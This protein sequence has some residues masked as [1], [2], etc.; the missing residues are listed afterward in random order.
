MIISQQTKEKMPRIPH[1]IKGPNEI[2]ELKNPNKVAE[3]TRGKVSVNEQIA[4]L[5]RRDALISR[6]TK[7]L[8]VEEK[9]SGEGVDIIE[10]AV[11]HSSHE[12]GVADASASV[13]KRHQF[14][15]FEDTSQKWVVVNFAHRNQRPKK[16]RPALRFL[17]AFETSVEADKYIEQA[18]P[19]LTGCNMWKL[20]LQGWMIVCKT[21]ARQQDAMYT[22]SKIEMLKQ[23]YMADKSK[24]NAEFSKN[25]EEKKQGEINESL[26]K[27]SKLAKE[28]HKKKVSSRLRALRACGK[29]GRKVNGMRNSEDLNEVS[30]LGTNNVPASLIQ[31]KQE[32]VVVSWM[33]DISRT[34][35]N[36]SDDPE[37]CCIVWRLFATYDMARDWMMGIGSQY[38]RD[39]DLEVVDNYEWLFPEDVDRDK[40]QEQYRHAEQNKVMLQ[41]K[42]EAEKVIDFEHWCEEKHIDV[43]VTDVYPDLE[44]DKGVRSLLPDELTGTLSTTTSQQTIRL[45]DPAFEL[46][47]ETKNPDKEPITLLKQ[48]EKDFDYLRRPTI[49][50]KFVGGYL[51]TMASYEEKKS[52]L[53]EKKDGPYFPQP[54]INETVHAPDE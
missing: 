16:D 20:P 13:E 46:K 34:H 2:K 54:P 43:P 48:S 25:K 50:P 40:I 14:S 22:S 5:E 12:K 7:Q 47:I 49:A 33:R 53:E 4:E 42:A 8:E 52:P 45:P 39:F 15:T 36:G 23:L 32:Y 10:Y 27:Q 31:R 24:R 6:K 38:I 19:L 41:R 3:Y 28:K 17:G 9:K 21:M 44:T 11:S 35:L 37:P 30:S 18:T 26:E 1:K 51:P 29:N